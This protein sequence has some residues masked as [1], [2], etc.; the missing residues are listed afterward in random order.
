MSAHLQRSSWRCLWF[1]C[2]PAFSKP[3]DTV[4]ALFIVPLGL[5][6]SLSLQVRRSSPHLPA[7]QPQL[8]H[9]RRAELPG[10][11][12]ITGN[13]G[14]NIISTLETLSPELSLW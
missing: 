12:I 1:S 8:G 9:D 6:I 2:S 14:S 11:R 13:K 7:L 4:R 3:N 5:Q 10:A